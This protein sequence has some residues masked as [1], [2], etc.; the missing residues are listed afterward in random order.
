MHEGGL[1]ALGLPLPFYAKGRA[2]AIELTCTGCGKVLS[3]PDAVEANATFEQRVAERTSLLQASHNE[4]EERVAERTKELRDAALALTQ[5][6]QEERRRLAHVLHDNLQQLIAAAKMQ[7]KLLRTSLN[8]DR[9]REHA[10]EA[11]SFLQQAIDVSRSLALE[12]SPPVLREQGFAAALEWLAGWMRDKHRLAVEVVY[13]GTKLPAD[14]TLNTFLF[15]SVRELLFNVTKHASVPSA[16]VT[17]EYTDDGWVRVYVE[18]DGPGFDPALLKSGAGL[19]LLSIRERARFFGG[20][21]DIDSAPGR[22]S[23]FTLHIPGSSKPA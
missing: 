6:E 8:D 22:G 16:R 20:G 7:V 12:L 5:A 10:A 17:V 14:G 15:E 3:V 13:D 9:G 23:R 1:N 4:L 2:M 11:D 18:D 19:G 21:F